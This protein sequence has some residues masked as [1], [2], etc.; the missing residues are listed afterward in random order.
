MLAEPQLR[1]TVVKLLMPMYLCVGFVDGTIH[2]WDI[3]DANSV[4]FVGHTGAIFSLAGNLVI[5]N[6]DSR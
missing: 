3:P 6:A 1:P 5:L 2:Y 4:R